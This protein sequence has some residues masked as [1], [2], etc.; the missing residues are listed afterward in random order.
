MNHFI[1]PLIFLIKQILILIP[2]FLMLFVIVKKI[3][4][5]IKIKN[6]KILFLIAINLIP[7]FLVLITSIFTGAK[8]RTMW[9]TPF[10]LFLGTLF[11]EIFK[12]NIELKKIKRFYYLFLLF[13][14]LSPSIYFGISIFD[15]TKRTDYPGKEISRLVQNKWNDNF[16]NDIKIVVGDEWSAGNLSYHLSSRPVWYNDLKNEISLIT[17]DQGVV[18]TGNPNIL[19]KLCPGVFG[20]ITPVGYCM[21][22][23]R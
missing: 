17:D 19:K 9:M 1:N 13:F 7:F 8:I 21:I 10:Y 18:Y 11:F 3:K 14:I 15:V 20:E 5:K 23:K 22:G 4:I 6:N 16:V 12:K 2:F